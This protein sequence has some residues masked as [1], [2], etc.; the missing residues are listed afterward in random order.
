MGKSSKLK[1]VL[2]ENHFV[3]NVYYYSIL[4][5]LMIV[6][7]VFLIRFNSGN[8][9]LFGEETYYHLNL[10][11]DIDLSFNL[12]KS[13]SPLDFFL[14][15]IGSLLDKL[16]LNDLL[17]LIAPFLGLL[18]LVFY[19]LFS[20]N[21]KIDKFENSI[22]LFFLILTPAIIYGFTTINN[23][24]GAILIISIGFFLLTCENK[25]LKY[26]APLFFLLI[27]LFDLFS[28]FLSLLLI[29]AYLIKKEQVVS[30]G[31]FSTIGK[32]VSDFSKNISNPDNLSKQIVGHPIRLSIFSLIS[33]MF[34]SWFYFNNGF[35]IKILFYEGFWLNIISDLGGVSGMS[36]FILVLVIIQL[37][38]FWRK[39]EE[40]IFYLIFFV[41]GIGFYFNSD[42]IIYFSFISC[43]LASKLSSYLIIRE[44]N[45][46]V[47]KNYVVLI[48]VISILFSTISFINRSDEIAPSKELVFV[49]ENLE[50]DY[51]NGKFKDDSRSNI[52]PKILS[53]SHN[54]FF[55]EYFTSLETFVRTAKPDE[56]V[57]KRFINF[58]DFKNNH[59][60][61]DSKIED[62]DIDRLKILE[63]KIK[64]GKPLSSKDIFEISYY[65][66]LSFIL[67]EN[68]IKFIL[69]DDT[70]KEL[71][72]PDKGLRFVLRNENFK[73]LYLQNKTELWEFDKLIVD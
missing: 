68:G 36:M 67:E 49:L 37:L 70:T 47:L 39:K 72:A 16:N 31:V 12:L 58:Y 29:I 45:L 62:Y 66:P 18:T 63:E 4:L 23:Q 11:N 69:V 3:R 25:L 65:K 44:W 41:S 35:P 71:F 7:L 64:L 13:L 38:F 55:L 53:L 46:K 22:F 40:M 9:L 14:S 28:A 51:V 20:K 43:Y 32:E 59:S 2:G 21:L 15:F 24:I 5:S 42:L 56:N 73:L 17:F 10:I 61:N 54:K 48:L 1:K 60:S 52:K 26:L 30:G 34:V 6:S 8:P 19:S 33:M 27:P 57:I 50:E